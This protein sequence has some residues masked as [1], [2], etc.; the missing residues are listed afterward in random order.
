MRWFLSGS[1]SP[2]VLPLLP[3]D[4]AVLKER[5][6]TISPI[7]EAVEPMVFAVVEQPPVLP[8]LRPALA[9]SVPQVAEWMVKRARDMHGDMLAGEIDPDNYPYHWVRA[10][11]T[12]ATI[13][14]PDVPS[15]GFGDRQG[16]I[17]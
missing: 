5:L 17:Y 8:A 4:L 12:L 1:D 16:R 14:D 13:D 6:A 10:V 3:P 2:E 15:Y 9:D 7:E 11:E